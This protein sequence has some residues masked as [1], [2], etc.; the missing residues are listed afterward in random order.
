[1]PLQNPVA[2]LKSQE[3]DLYPG[4]DICSEMFGIFSTLPGKR[5]KDNLEKCLPFAAKQGL[6]GD[7][8]RYIFSEIRYSTRPSK[9]E[10][11]IREKTFLTDKK[12]KTRTMNTGFLRDVTT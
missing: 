4:S 11:S 6:V 9:V 10:R 3:Q 7:T 2:L 5:S 1:M 8:P 12:W